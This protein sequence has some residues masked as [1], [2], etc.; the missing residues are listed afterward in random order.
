MAFWKKNPLSLPKSM[1]GGVG[2]WLFIS[3]MCGSC[4]L[5]CSFIVLAWFIPYIGLSAIHQTLPLIL[6]TLSFLLIF[7]IAWMCIA[8]I[9]YVY[10]GNNIWGLRK[11]HGITVKLMYPLMDLLGR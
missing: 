3:L 5:H 6:G 7:C 1:Y 9:Y 10:T 8:L 11:V 2:K 4:V